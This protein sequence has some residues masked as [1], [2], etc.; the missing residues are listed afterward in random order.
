[1]VGGNGD[2]SD[3][4]TAADAVDPTAISSGHNVEEESEFHDLT[5]EFKGAMDRPGFI[6]N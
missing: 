4:S 1:V 5:M 2:A 6:G 3:A